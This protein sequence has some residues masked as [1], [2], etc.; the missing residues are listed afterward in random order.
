MINLGNLLYL[1]KTTPMNNDDLVEEMLEHPNAQIM[2]NKVQTAL[3][4]EKKERLAYRKWLKDN[5]KAE[6]INGEIVMHSPVKRGHLIVSDNLHPLLTTFIA[7]N[8]LGVVSAE[9]AL[10][11]LTRNDYEP[12]ICYWTNEQAKGFNKKTMVHPAPMLV[13]EILSKG[14]AKNDR[15]IKFKDYASHGIKE[16]WIIDPVKELLEQY[17]LKSK[18]SIEYTLFAKLSEGEN[19]LESFVL[20]DFKIPLAA[21]FDK[22]EQLKALRKILNN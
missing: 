10:I 13:V 17:I 9:K 12:D 3:N 8:K 1:Y 22:R 11:A 20:A 21:I 18:S 14:T 6:F 7:V 5:V 15:G 4:K 19:I 2:V 16:Y